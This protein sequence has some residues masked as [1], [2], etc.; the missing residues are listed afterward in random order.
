MKNAY[1]LLDRSGACSQSSVAAA[2]TSKVGERL[3]PR[4]HLLELLGRGLGRRM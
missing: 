2:R 3:R 4:E 1:G